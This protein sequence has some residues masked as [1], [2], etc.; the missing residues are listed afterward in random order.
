VQI[1]NIDDIGVL[2]GFLPWHEMAKRAQS[3]LSSTEGCRHNAD[4]SADFMLRQFYAWGTPFIGGVFLDTLSAVTGF[5]AITPGSKLDTSARW[6]KSAS[7]QFPNGTYMHE[8]PFV[9]MGNPWSSCNLATV[10]GGQHSCSINAHVADWFQGGFPSS[11]HTQPA[12]IEVTLS[13]DCPADALMQGYVQCRGLCSTGN[14]PTP[15]D[16]GC[17]MMRKPFVVVSG[18]CPQGYTRQVVNSSITDFLFPRDA[19][20]TSQDTTLINFLQLLATRKFEFDATV[21][22]VAT[23]LGS[24][25]GLCFIDGD[26][27]GDNIGNWAN[28][29]YTESCPIPFSPP[30][31]GQDGCPQI[32]STG[33]VVACGAAPLPP[34]AVPPQP[35]TCPA[36]G[37]PTGPGPC[38]GPACNA[39]GAWTIVPSLGVGA[40]LLV[41]S[42]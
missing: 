42:A 21:A 26:G 31:T 27:F 40:M 32:L 16:T 38:V 33:G 35:S 28:A 25:N 2:N 24:S 10:T 6:Y 39:A 18:T 9:N 12:S 37:C 7:S 14:S 29:T 30:G 23:T 1:G 17:C 15:S 20:Q 34:C 4:T 11:W 13:S 5:D 36:T 41:L 22:F 3:V 8:A 19:N